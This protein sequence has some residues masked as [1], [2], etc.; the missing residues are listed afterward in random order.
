M[1][2]AKPLYF[3]EHLTVSVW[4]FHVLPYLAR[5]KPMLNGARHTTCY[6]LDGT[7][8]GVWIARITAKYVSVSVEQFR[9]KIEE[10]RDNDDISIFLK[11]LYL[12]SIRLKDEIKNDQ[13]FEEYLDQL[14]VGTRFPF[15]LQK[16]LHSYDMFNSGTYDHLLNAQMLIR[17]CAW[18]YRQDGCDKAFLFL[19]R[20]LWFSF[21]EREAT[22]KNITLIS[23]PR[24]IQ[25]NLKNIAR[26][27]FPKKLIHYIQYM[28]VNKALPSAKRSRD[29][30]SRNPRL[31]S[32]YNGHLNLD[33]PERYSDLFFLEQ[34]DLVGSDILLSFN[35]PSDPLD[36]LKNDQLKRKGIVAIALSPA[37]TRLK[38]S[39]IYDEYPA[40]TIRKIKV[41]KPEM[42]WMNEIHLDYNYWRSYWTVFFE[43][44]KIRLYTSWLKYDTAHFAIADAMDS[45]GGITTIYQR[46]YQT[47]PLPSTTMNVDIAFSFSQDGAIMEK[48]NNS[49]ITYYVAVGY[50][51]DHRFPML[52]EK[53]KLIRK[54]LEKKGA[55]HIL[56]YFDENTI[57]DPRWYLDH[58]YAMDNYAFLLQKVLQ[59]K[60]FGLLLKPKN[61]AT[62]LK[63][64]GPVAAMIEKAR[65]TGRCHLFLD[66]AVQGSD[67]P[68]LAALSADVAVHDGI[69]SP[70]AGMESAFCGVPTLLLDREG[71]PVSNLY[72]LGV[73][74]VVFQDWETL[75][76]GYNSYIKSRK[77]I[78]GFGDWTPLLAELDPF[79]D[80][81][82]AE[83]MGK[84][85]KWLLD[86]LKAGIGKESIMADA[87]E[88]YRKEWGQD[89][90]S[91]VEPA[92]EF[93]LK[94]T[95]N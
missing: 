62:L 65:A 54:K 87:A 92:Y 4:L 95:H 16:S 81:R 7:R 19:R 17:I 76:D 60:E 93:R 94:K 9:Y 63:R 66:G 45:L 12:D 83:R 84:Y 13:V 46:S 61:P 40:Q 41:K 53:A 77:K 51:G 85:L 37:A 79:R 52:R 3:L 82:A 64:L 29:T 1:L 18:K 34:S 48:Q 25:T 27:K 47:A 78:T 21:F 26:K 6:Y 86:G 90:V 10:I 2:E 44:Y 58:S 15:Y 33:N 74:S 75:W 39:I 68:A 91:S 36:D 28:M 14:S 32:E 89:K 38:D 73:G 8:T 23:L 43:K 55:Q 22:Q 67:P 31:L 80:G 20:R 71:W 72:R 11:V 42:R 59:D 69:T 5:N 50:I 57:D 49:K 70:T 24:K 30:I 56:T 88:R 35:L